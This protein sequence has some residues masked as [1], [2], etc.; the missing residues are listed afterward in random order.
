[1]IGEADTHRQ[2]AKSRAWFKVGAVVLGVL[3]IEVC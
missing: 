2:G 1:M 3:F